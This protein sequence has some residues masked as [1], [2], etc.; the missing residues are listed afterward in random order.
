[1]S[2]FRMSSHRLQF[3]RP[4]IWARRKSPRRRLRPVRIHTDGL[5][6]ILHVSRRNGRV[7][8]PMWTGYRPANRFVDIR[9]SHRAA[10]AANALDPGPRPLRTEQ[11]SAWT[12]SFHSPR[13]KASVRNFI[14]MVAFTTSERFPSSH[15]LP[16]KGLADPSP[17]KA[18][19]AVI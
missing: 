9:N 8:E 5:S 18:G 19:G 17:P 13:H 3:P 15:S 14:R 1:V 6:D 16:L 10:S 11:L 2:A 7:V 4:P 12:P